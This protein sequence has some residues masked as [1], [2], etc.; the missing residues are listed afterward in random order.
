MNK[1][2]WGNIS[3]TKWIKQEMIELETKD[4]KHKVKVPKHLVDT[5]IKVY[6]KCGA[7]NDEFDEASNALLEAVIKADSSLS[8]CRGFNTNR[9]N[10][11]M[12]MC[13]G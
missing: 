3:W 2:D 9:L 5:Y 6:I 11:T 8:Q 12:Y 4:G 7:F 10:K 13:I 1:I